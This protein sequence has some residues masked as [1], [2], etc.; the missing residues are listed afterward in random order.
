MFKEIESDP[1]MRQIALALYAGTQAHTAQ[2]VKDTAAGLTQTWQQAKEANYGSTDAQMLSLQSP[3]FPNIG[4]NVDMTPEMMTRLAV[5]AG[6]L[7]S[8]GR[9]QKSDEVH[10][11]L[12]AL[13][14]LGEYLAKTRD[15]KSGVI[16][17]Q[18][19]A[20]A[21]GISNGVIIQ[22]YQFGDVDV[23]MKGGVLYA[24]NKELD[25][26][27]PVED[28]LEDGD[29]RQAMH[30]FIV[31]GEVNEQL[32][33]NPAEAKRIQLAYQKAFLNVDSE[34]DS[35]KVKDLHKLPLMTT[36]YGMDAD[37]HGENIGKF[38]GNNPDIEK[39]LMSD[40]DINDQS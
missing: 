1:E 16:Q 15:G 4:L 7:D 25:E 2:V 13:R 3:Q 34:V 26:F 38:L 24:Y 5:V 21:D 33:M 27:H 17:T 37:F 19:T 10:F 14:D 20:E 30:S 29:L 18:I 28:I 6:L 23:L 11:K 40:L 12:M 31:D 9:P 32:A 36:V 39:S 8:K 35:G 22:G